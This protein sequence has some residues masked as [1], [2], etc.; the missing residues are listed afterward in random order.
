LI[1]FDDASQ[2][3]RESLARSASDAYRRRYGRRPRWIAA[4]PGRVNLIGEHIDYNDGFALPMAIERHAILAGDL[5][6]DSNRDDIRVTSINLDDDAVLTRNPHPTTLSKPWARYIEGVVAGF[7]ERGISVPAW[8]G[9]LVSNVPLGGGL[10][11]SAAL[12]VAA[13]TML[14]AV[15]GVT[16]PTIEKALLCQRAEHRF[17]GVPCGIMDQYSSVHGQQDRLLLLDCRSI[18]HRFVPFPSDE[19]TVL[20][21]NS[22]VRHELTGGEYA[23]RRSQCD[24]ALKKLTRSS[25]RDVT[26]DELADHGD[27]LDATERRRARHVVTEI[28]RTLDAADA[29]AHRDWSHVGRLMDA[30]HE[31]L[32][33]DFEVSCRELDLLV[34]IARSLGPQAGVIGSRMTGGGFGGCTVTLVRTQASADIAKEIGDRYRA[35]TGIQPDVFATRPAAGAE[36]LPESL[37]R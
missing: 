29:I 32:R 22:N 37:Q 19:V 11:S 23:Q 12:E 9:V 15:T 27:N 5:A 20:I 2:S 33:V 17:A 13:A 31:S 10:S 3:D 25:W 28:A 26:L 8:D 21:T 34:D 4:A 18:Q 1:S 30:S 7:L 35:E 16:L 24:A 6:Y 36:L 14:E